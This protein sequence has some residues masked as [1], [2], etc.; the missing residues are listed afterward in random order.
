MKL[1]T[2]EITDSLVR[3]RQLYIDVQIAEKNVINILDNI[4]EG[5]IDD[6]TIELKE[7][8]KC[9]SEGSTLKEIITG[10]LNYGEGDLCEIINLI[11]TKSKQ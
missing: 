7:S 5:E 11:E 3:T 2:N 4:F 8:L 10:Y 1:N 6:I 9:K